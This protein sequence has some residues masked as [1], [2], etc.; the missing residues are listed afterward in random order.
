MGL[1]GD[2]R[3]W[4]SLALTVLLW[5]CK[6]WYGEGVGVRDN[7]TVLQCEVMTVTAERRIA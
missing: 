5:L 1:Y 3:T 4:F 2:A 6:T 7:A